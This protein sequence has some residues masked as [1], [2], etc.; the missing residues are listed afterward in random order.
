MSFIHC[1]DGF[2][3]SCCFISRINRAYASLKARKYYLSLF[4]FLYTVEIV[5]FSSGCLTS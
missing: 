2:G 3:G 4:E 1:C 5:E